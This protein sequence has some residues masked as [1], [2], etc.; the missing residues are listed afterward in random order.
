MKKM[1]IG[2]GEG[3]FQGFMARHV[4]KCV[5]VA[6]ILLMAWF[7]Y[8]GAGKTDVNITRERL[9]QNAQEAETKITT[10]RWDVVAPDRIPRTDVLDTVRKQTGKIDSRAY[11]YRV[12]DAPLVPKLM[13]RL[14]PK[15]IAAEKVIATP[16]YGP[17]VLM[18]PE[19]DDGRMP[20]DRLEKFEVVIGGTGYQ[21]NGADA[22]EEDEDKSKSARRT[23]EKSTPMPGGPP[24]GSMPPGAKSKGKKGDD[25]YATPSSSNFSMMSGGAGARTISPEALQGVKAN[26]GS[27]IQ[28]STAMVITAVVPY[29]KQ[30]DE[31]RLAFKD[32]PGGQDP[33][34]DIP[35]Y[36]QVV[37]RRLDVTADPSI[38]PASVP[39]SDWKPVDIRKLS[40]LER[41]YGALISEIADVDATDPELTHPVPPFL[42][43]DLRPVMLHPD[44]ER[45]SQAV[46][47]FEEE[48]EAEFVETDEGILM[49]EDSDEEDS[50]SGGFNRP[51]SRMPRG[52]GGFSPRGSSS[53]GPPPGSGGFGGSSR[54]SSMGPPPGP[55][56]GGRSRMGSGGMGMGGGF[57]GGNMD[58][59]T[60]RPVPKK[61]VR[62]VDFDAEVGHKY[63]YR[64]M[65]V[66]EDPNRP[67]DADMDP[68]P[69]TLDDKV[70]ERIK[71]LE[72]AEAK[73]QEADK[74]NVVKRR[75]YVLSAW[76]EPSAVVG[77]PSPERFYASET[78]PATTIPLGGMSIA[79]NEPSSKVLAVTWDPTLGVFAPAEQ[80]VH[81][82]S[83]LN[84]KADIE[85]VHPVLND[86]R[87]VPEY[88][89]KTDG[90][91]LDIAGGEKLPGTAE[92]KEIIRAP[93]ETLIMD[94]SGNLIVTD[95]AR[96]IEGYRRYVFPEPK[97]EPNKRA[98]GSDSM[99]PP[100]GS[101]SMGPP[102]GSGSKGGPP[103]SAG[104][105]KGGPPPSGSGYPSGKGGRPKGG[106]PPGR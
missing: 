76:S 92:S 18:P 51:A 43:T 31:Y 24:P 29:S 30:W 58:L 26:V 71:A 10:S 99:G 57:G 41:K 102:P 3:G 40:A 20:S 60:Y 73:R 2:F 78:I 86:L 94:A 34:R 36:M 39:D 66:L 1:K 7:I 47:T 103:P 101:S 33:T 32:A 64:V 100:S 25:P 44:V 6:V 49:E 55:G 77:M 79:T 4:E 22:E 93:G 84:T 35:N 27:I 50:S 37:V 98:D 53:M 80:T 69:T 59:E 74:E 91:V 8:S 62:F 19:T 9:K 85:V 95:E 61:L 38:D 105:S 104:G 28:P 13:P 81:R 83:V 5:L 75:N 88:E 70:R 54:G 106:R 21:S 16:L 42:L 89:L 82:A 96:D 72:V 14:D 23:R 56:S 87:K 17:L 46:M 97:E 67:R 90:V 45:A 52:S 65:L 68:D 48:G 63:R 15:I 11:A 12:L